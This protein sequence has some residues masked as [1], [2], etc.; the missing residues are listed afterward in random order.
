[1]KTL[2]TNILSSSQ[3]SLK[4]FI[5]AKIPTFYLNQNITKNEVLLQLKIENKTFLEVLDTMTTGF[6]V[7]SSKFEYFYERVFII[8]NI[9]LNNIN[10]LTISPFIHIHLSKQLSQYQIYYYYLVLNYQNFVER[11]ESIMGRLIIQTNILGFSCMKIIFISISLNCIFY[12][13]FHIVLVIY[14]LIYYKLIIDLCEEIENKMNLKNDNIG[15][16][17]MFLKKNEK[18]KIIVSLYK[19]DIYQ[20]IVDLNFIYDN[21]K[22]FIEEKKIEIEKYLKKEKYSSNT[23]IS[24]KKNKKIKI[25]HII[26]IPENKR[27]FY[28]CLITLIY[29]IIL[30][31]IFFIIWASYFIVYNRINN[32]FESHG[33]LSND[34]YKFINYYQLMIYQNFTIEDINNFQ[35]YNKSLGE[36]IFSNMF[37]DLQ[38]LYEYKKY[39][40]K[41]S[42]YNLGNINSY[43]N[44][45]CISYYEYLFSS[46]DFLGNID[47]TFKNYLVFACNNS[48]VFQSNNNYKQL[49]TILFTNIQSGINEI[50]GRSYD[51]L[52]KVAHNGNLPKL[53]IYFLTVYHYAFQIMGFQLQRQSSERINSLMSSY[54]KLS[55]S[56]YYISSIA[57]ILVIIFVY[58]F[59]INSNYNKIQEIKK[60]FKVCNK[61][62]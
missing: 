62:E 31:I 6:L 35:K 60:V 23:K 4:N 46:N 32:L 19:Q 16:K 22:K 13:L 59:K 24:I 5:N 50:K 3:E 15:V 54:I 1:M 8:N 11:I 26:K 61:K 58:I 48:K 41:L 25:K 33:N 55:F 2:I 10:N 39:M 47:I 40:D 17:E 42:Q 49:F 52:I 12:L 9:N 45:T 29:S 27:Y 34:A 38:A 43:Y 18:L 44:Y 7:M 14:I 20:A 28:Y 53:I 36:D 57:F 30:N 21:Y 51:E 56:L 37:N